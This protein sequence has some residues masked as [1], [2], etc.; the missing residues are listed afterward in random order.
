MHFRDERLDMLK[1]HEEVE[2]KSV[3]LDCQNLFEF[4]DER[5]NEVG[6]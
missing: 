1:P 4:V 3:T 5:F 6:I 2:R